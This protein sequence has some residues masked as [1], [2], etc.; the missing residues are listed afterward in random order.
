[1]SAA[2]ARMPKPTPPKVADQQLFVGGKWQ[3]SASGKTFETLNPATGD[4]ICRAQDEP[5]IK[6]TRELWTAQGVKF[7][8][9]D[10]AEVMKRWYARRDRG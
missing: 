5:F 4:V 10:G 9:I 1:M 2:T 6:R 8:V 7:E 3:A